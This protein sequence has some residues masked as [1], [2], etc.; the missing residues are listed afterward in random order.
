[1]RNTSGL[2]NASTDGGTRRVSAVPWRLTTVTRTAELCCNQMVYLTHCILAKCD[3]C[4]QRTS[5]TYRSVAIRNKE[6]LDMRTAVAY[7]APCTVVLGSPFQGWPQID[8]VRVYLVRRGGQTLYAYTDRLT[9][10][11]VFIPV[12]NLSP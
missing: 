9:P 6:L 12:H 5:T 10:D 4:K 11:Y 2:P 1:M 8:A 3:G 7:A